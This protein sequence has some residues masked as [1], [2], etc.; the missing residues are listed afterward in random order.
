MKQAF[1]NFIVSIM[2]ALAR[3]AL[4][5]YQAKIVAIT[6][7]VGKTSTK[8][9]VAAA[10]MSTGA[11]VRKNQKSYNSEIGLP[12][13]ILDVPNG[14]SNPVRWLFI[15]LRGAYKA[16]LDPWRPEW[17]VLEVGAD[18]P[19]DITR[20]VS[21]LPIDVA[22]FT[23]F[24][25]LPVHAANFPDR[26][27]HLKEKL[28]LLKGLKPEG[29]ILV[30]SDDAEF[31]D[32][33]VAAS[34]GQRVV[35]YG[36]LDPTDIKGSPLEFISESGE[37]VG[38]TFTVFANGVRLEIAQRG[39]IGEQ[40][41]YPSLAA[42][43]CVYMS[44]LPLTA[45]EA[46]L[47]E[48]TFEPGR[49]RLLSGLKNT[50][51]IDDSYNS[52]PIA[53]ER[54]FS[55]LRR[56]TE[57]EADRRLFLILGDMNELGDYTER[58]HKRLGELVAELGA[59]LYYVGQQFDVVAEGARERGAGELSLQSFAKALDAANALEPHLKASDIIFIKGS[60]GGIRLERAVK[61]LMAEP[62]QASELLV[63]QGAEWDK[64]N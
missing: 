26:E 41:V 6:G 59:P 58:A 12:L 33:I 55:V 13:A 8:D 46:A 17:L 30:N 5:R 47:S 45:L 35:R 42:V 38:Q 22:L 52:S 60:Q 23:Q 2:T 15:I 20:A 3:Q 53:V 28:E 44:D 16:W 11:R 64:R 32:R 51:I 56:L 9:A 10:L 36:F 43:A 63:R 40:H 61:E 54:A 27:T 50:L 19:G 37:V 4:K 31:T 21:W 7:T 18:T 14:W 57:R 39:V 24:G 29:F 25:E 49:M 1:K 62:E 34:V 48:R